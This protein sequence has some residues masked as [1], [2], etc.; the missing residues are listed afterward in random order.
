[1]Y[2][3]SY[4][5]YIVAFSPET[6]RAMLGSSLAAVCR[7]EQGRIVAI[8]MAESGIVNTGTTEWQLVE[9]SETATD[10][11]Y[12]SRGLSQLCKV[13]LIK[14]VRAAPKAD[15]ILVY[16]ESRANH[17]PVLAANVKLGMVPAGRLDRHCRIASDLL[18]V[19]QEGVYGNLF[20]FY[21]PL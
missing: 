12:L 10:P 2:A 17:A 19:P 18:D 11:D 13:E 1:M 7:N 16:A 20:V 9:L 5:E 4:S 3:Q 14:K 6:I 15:R 8:S 21:L